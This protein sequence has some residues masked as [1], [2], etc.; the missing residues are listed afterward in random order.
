MTGYDRSQTLI[1]SEVDTRTD[2]TIIS[3]AAATKSFVLVYF[4]IHWIFLTGTQVPMKS[5]CF[6]SLVTV[7]AMLFDNVLRCFNI[8][9]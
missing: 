3:A 2:G 4:Q 7:T 9:I 1:Q 5:C 8:V 6:S